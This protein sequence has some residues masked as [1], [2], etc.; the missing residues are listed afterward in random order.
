MR[1]ARKSRKW[2]EDKLELSKEKYV[3]ARY[4]TISLAEK[5]RFVALVPGMRR[6]LLPEEWVIVRMD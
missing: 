3:V 1:K 5:Q 6:P 4:N 2:N